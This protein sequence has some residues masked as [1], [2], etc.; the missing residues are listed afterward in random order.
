[1]KELNEN[2]LRPCMIIDNPHIFREVISETRPYFTHKGAEGIVTQMRDEIDTYATRFGV[3][4]DR[5][6]RE[7]Y[8]NEP[9]IPPRCA[10]TTV[11]LS[12]SMKSG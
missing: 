5:I 1:M 6:W 3:F 12:M 8:L 2:Y 7:E 4:A 10:S 9:S 11:G